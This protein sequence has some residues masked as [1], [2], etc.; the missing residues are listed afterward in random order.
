MTRDI[1]IGLNMYRDVWYNLLQF[2]AAYDLHFPKGY[3]IRLT[4]MLLMKMDQSWALIIQAAL[5]M[6]ISIIL[7]LRQKTFLSLQIIRNWV[8]LHLSM[9]IPICI[10]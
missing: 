4:F 2:I 6:F 5:T 1:E 3:T 7:C 10:D 8:K 9:K